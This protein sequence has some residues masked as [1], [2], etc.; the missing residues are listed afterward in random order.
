[1]CVSLQKKC[2][3]Q[4]CKNINIRGARQLWKVSCWGCKGDTHK[5]VVKW[6]LS[7]ITT[8]WSKLASYQKQQ[9]ILKTVIEHP[10]AIQHLSYS[11]R[12]FSRQF[13]THLFVAL[14]K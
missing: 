10:S 1:M 7:Q 4:D 13:S 11:S 14:A 9:M 3:Q 8:S 6:R 12:H 5:G 2:A